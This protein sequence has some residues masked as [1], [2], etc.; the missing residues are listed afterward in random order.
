[1]PE[2]PLNCRFRGTTKSYDELITAVEITILDQVM[3]TPILKPRKTD[4]A[5]IDIGIAA[6]DDMSEAKSDEDQGITDTAAQA[7]QK[8]AG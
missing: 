6:K 1:M 7:V 5:P 4:T 3:P 2:S 8:G